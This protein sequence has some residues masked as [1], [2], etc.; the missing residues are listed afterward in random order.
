MYAHFPVTMDALIK[1]HPHTGNVLLSLRAK[2]INEVEPGLQVR[3]VNV[4]GELRDLTENP[5]KTP[6]AEAAKFCGLRVHDVMFELIEC[7]KAANMRSIDVTWLLY[8][9]GP[10]EFFNDRD[11]ESDTV[12]VMIRWHKTR[13][14]KPLG[15][16]G[17]VCMMYDLTSEIP[18]GFDD[19]GV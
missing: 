9:L 6:R 11:E 15:T 12:C 10:N 4:A 3:A 18:V 8:N 2:S 16:R 19:I 14:F 13:L 1:M 7:L 17:M 5:F